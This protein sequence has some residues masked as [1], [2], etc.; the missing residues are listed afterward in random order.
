[1]MDSMLFAQQPSQALASQVEKFWYCAG[2]K[3]KHSKERVLPSGKFQIILDLRDSSFATGPLV[4]GMQSKHSIIE[5]H[6]LQ[7]MIGILF[8]PGGAHPFLKVPADEFRDRVVPLELIW[9]SAG[10]GLRDRIREAISP[11]QKF[12]ILDAVL[13][14]RAETQCQLSTAVRY[15]LS[16]FQRVPHVQ[17][18]LEVTKRSGLSR[19]RL[20]QLFREQVGL[21]PKR[22]CRILR[23]QQV[24]RQIATG[25]AIDWAGLA[26]ATGYYD[27][28]H[29]AHEFREF[30]GISPGS[31][32][33]HDQRWK[34][35]VPVA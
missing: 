4:V 12:R 30:S 32:G 16:E 24:V 25:Q 11:A 15:A 26:L 10:A 9:G 34:N 29:L 31:Y 22:Y 21:T 8:R 33:V 3:A 2:Y 5:A 27:Q 13:C 17:R 14:H 18:V 1:M 35:H 19:R 7:S 20:A 23:F 28:S 6:G